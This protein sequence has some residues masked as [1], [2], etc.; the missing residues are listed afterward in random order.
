[1][2]CKCHAHIC[3]YNVNAVQVVDNTANLN[4]AFWSTLEIFSEY[5]QAVVS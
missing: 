2:Q 5:F 1:M 4:F 3:K